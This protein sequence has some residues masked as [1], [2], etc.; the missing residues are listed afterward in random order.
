M[1]YPLSYGRWGFALASITAF[2]PAWWSH[3]GDTVVSQGGDLRGDLCGAA[4]A[5]RR[6]AVQASVEAAGLGLR[7]ESQGPDSAGLLP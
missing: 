4:D 7:G 2:A 1:L 5:T 6:H 3:G